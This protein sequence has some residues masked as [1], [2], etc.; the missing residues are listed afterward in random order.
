MVILRLFNKLCVTK[1]QYQTITN[2]P[3]IKTLQVVRRSKKI[4]SYLNWR[5]DT[6][7]T[8]KERLLKSVYTIENIFRLLYFVVRHLCCVSALNVLLV[9]DRKRDG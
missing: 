5:S 7:M 1:S 6:R 4:Q 8:R 2:I 3:R 9:W